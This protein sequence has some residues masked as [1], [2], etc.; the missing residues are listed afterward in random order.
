MKTLAI[1]TSCDET[2]VAVLGPQG[3]VLA[4]LVSSQ[5]A[6]HAPYLGVVPELAARH[7]VEVLPRLMGALEQQ[8]L[9]GDLE[10]VAVTQGP[11]LIGSLLVGTCYASAFA[12]ARNLPLSA[13]DH[14]EGH[15][16]SPF[17]NLE[18]RPAEAIPDGALTLV[19]SGGHSSYFLFSQGR[20]VPLNRTRDDAAGEVFD[21]V[22]AALGLGYPGG[23]V[24]D[25]LAENGDPS[26]FRFSPPRI[27]DPHGE[28]DFSF[29]GLKS[30]VIRKAQELGK[31]L[32]AGTSH[33]LGQNFAKA[34]EIQFT[35]E[36]ND[37]QYCWTTS[38]GVST[39][40][41]GAI[42]MAHGDDQGLRL[43]PKLAPIQVVIVPI[44]REESQ[45]AS[46]MAA[47][48]Q[49]KAMLHEAGLRVHL[50]DRDNFSPGYKF[51]DWE[52]R[53][54]PLRLEIGPKDVANNTVALAR[55][56]MPG[57][58]GK[59]FVSQAGLVGTVRDLLD[60]IQ[61]SLLRQATEF[62]DSHLHEVT[63][64]YQDFI[65]VVR[66]GEWALAWFCESAACEERVKEDAQA[67]SRNFPLEQP[68]PGEQGKCIVCG[69]PAREM[70]YFAKA[71]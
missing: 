48:A 37:L 46:V 27:K 53:G 4:N 49:I 20:G 69:Q 50:D 34:F 9:L 19:V 35:D 3:E 62:R 67:V 55:R 31:A 40:M 43:P 23:P 32:Q 30:A 63:S 41:V 17:M 71:Y 28:L 70:A 6:V 52:M 24:V 15:L 8:G 59:R 5:V 18:G 16:V 25:R 14:L 13:V 12:Y 57:K 36:N 51:N 7:H 33:D 47:A 56:D 44:F 54:V 39:R 68:H 29:S 22:A 10:L 65:E 61:A 1:E 26:A 21:K 60:D 58:E 45:R 42:V 2:S 64:N 11:G 66:G 38:W